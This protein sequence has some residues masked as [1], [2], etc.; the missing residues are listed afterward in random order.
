VF[1]LFAISYLLIA[2][3]SAH[4]LDLSD[5]DIQWVFSV[6][7]ITI[8]GMAISRDSSMR[9]Q[10]VLDMCFMWTAWIL[11]TSQVFELS[12]EAQAAETFFFGLAVAWQYVR[13]YHHTSH[14]A[15]PDTVHIAFY[16]G[17]NAPFLSRMGAL[18]GYSVSSVAVV[19]GTRAIRP[20]KSLGAMKECS[21]RVLEDKGYVFINTGVSTNAKMFAALKEIDRTKT[22]YK[23]ARTKCL[24]SLI[25][26]LELLGPKWIPGKWQCIPTF[27]YQKCVRNR[28]GR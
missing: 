10:S 1:L 19:V 2:I 8:F 28:H 14:P 20:S 25:P 11:A 13:A 5:E 17:P 24:V 4:F 15:N 12:P 16:G 18:M 26:I 3:A 22:G 7:S 23:H 6:N 21:V 9:Q 27:Y